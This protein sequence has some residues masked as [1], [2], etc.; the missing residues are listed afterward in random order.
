MGERILIIEDNSANME[1]MIFL[2]KSF[3]YQPVLAFD[4]QSGID[5]AHSTRPALI[6]CDVNLPGLSGVGVVRSLKNSANL[7][8][9]PV[10]AVTSMTMHGDEG[11]ILKAGF[12][13][14]IGKPF[15]PLMLRRVLAAHLDGRGSTADL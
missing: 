6:I 3:G 14:Y 11:R 5:L 10:I 4:G 13:G 2:L 9:V 15:D 1:L 12:D 8:T 7:R